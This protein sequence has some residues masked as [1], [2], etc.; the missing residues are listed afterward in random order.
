MRFALVVAALPLLAADPYRNLP[1]T[2]EPNR[3]QADPAVQY[4][5]RGNGY[6]V[7]LAA[8]SASL[9][10][11]GAG[12]V[13]FRLAAAA[14]PSFEALD[15][16]PGRSHYYFGPDPARWLT[17]I[18]HYARVR[19]RN[20]YPGI[21]LVYYGNQRELE[22]DFVVAPGADADRIRLVW[23]GVEGLRQDAAG[24]LL[25]IVSGREIR[26]RRPRVFQ[27]RDGREQE[28][29][30]RYRLA[31]N[32]RVRFDISEYD[33]ALPLVIDPVLVYSTLLG[34]NG[35]EEAR[36]VTADGQGSAFVAGETESLIFPS[37]GGAWRGFGQG[38]TDAF[39]TRLNPDGKSLRYSTHFGGSEAD[40]ATALALDP[41]GNVYVTGWTQSN[42][43]FPVTPIVFQRIFGGGLRDVYVAKFSSFGTLTYCTYLGGTGADM[44]LAVA[45]DAAGSAFVAGMTDSVDF[46]ASPGAAQAAYG[47]GD[48][49]AFVAKLAPNGDA[50]VYATYLGGRDLDSAFAVAAD[51]AG[52]AYLTGDTFSRN[53]PTT[54]GALRRE[55]GPSFDAFVSK[56]NP[57]GTALAYSTYLGGDR[58]TR[59]LSIALDV[60]GNAYV[61]G[62]T[63]AGDFP[64]TSGAF[65]SAAGG[66]RDGF[67]AKLDPAGGSLAYATY[68]GGS[69]DDLAARV[70]VDQEGHAYVAGSTASTD[71][72]TTPGALQSASGGGQDAFLAVLNLAGSGLVHATYLGGAR[73]DRGQGVAVDFLGGVYLVGGVE[74][75]GFPTEP[76]D[77][78]QR[79]LRGTRDSF[80]AKLDLASDIRALATSPQRLVFRAITGTAPPNQTLKVVAPPGSPAPGWTAE[81]ASDRGG[82][83]LTIS[84]A[85]G[86]GSADLTVAADARSLAAGQYTARILLA[87]QVTGG[88]LTIPVTLTVINPV[89]PISAAGVVNGASF[90]GGPISAGEI[91]TIFAPGIGPPALTPLQLTA[92][93][94]LATTLA[95]TRVL[96]QG[97]AAPLIYV[98]ERQIS[99]LVPY[100]VASRSLVDLQV[101]YLGFRSNTVSLSVAPST[102]GLF[103]LN[104]SGSGPGA[105]L[106]QDYSV[107]SPS[108]PAERGSVVILYGTGQ[109][110][111]DN[112][113]DGALGS[114]TS[115]SKPR[116]PVSVR[117]SGT[118]A[119]VLYAGSAPGLVI[120][121]IQIN[122]RVPTNIP[123]GSA[124]PVTFT[125]GSATSQAGVTIAVR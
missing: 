96:F 123:A 89:G 36:A 117:I 73:D 49:D 62:W 23:E 17:D 56:L 66:G 30:G 97:T 118:P 20:V 121:L 74:S 108:N 85:R 18:P 2:F 41:A 8:T 88:R 105:V 106:N 112:A 28:I 25:L 115:P 79:T 102:P 64:A 15:P 44:A 124:V 52:G 87:N 119:E 50:L 65:Q 113:G 40:F 71:F 83:W 3:G 95:E 29:E 60:P 37:T 58:A 99:A 61:A 103:T 67:V 14:R 116:L 26:Q 42:R 76:S 125:V 84:T 70:D 110:N 114:A 27:R 45:A 104:S 12:A 21:D 109:G 98:S 22:Y 120:G 16:L 91:V 55:P 33:R 122:A 77:A 92:S 13:S 4:V 68:L 43:T 51:S 6:A 48:S 69:G 101:E 78:Y 86:E 59:G 39:L 111:L 5:A 93:R 90:A 81:A 9:R 63:Q 47:G 75:S 35:T 34:G 32:R 53:F 24:D 46:P 7:S 54:A 94:R 107:N 31:G 80:V 38:G 100:V 10:V 1:L 19:A 72:P 57:A 11:R 82:R